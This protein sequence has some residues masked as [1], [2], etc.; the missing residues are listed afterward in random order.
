VEADPAYAP[1]WAR[2][3]RVNRVLGGYSGGD[4]DAYYREAEAAFRRALE[5]NPD[6]SLAHNLYT[7]L[8]VE[9]GQ[10]EAALLRLVARAHRHTGDPELFAGLVQACRYCGLL[11][12]SVA[13]YEHARRL[14]AHIR[15]SVAHA[16]FALGDYERAIATNVEDPPVLTAAALDGLGRTEEAV[17]L[18]RQMDEAPLPKVYRLFIGSMRAL[19]EGAH[20][21]ARDALR[22]M[23]QESSLRDPC[24]WYYIAR[25]MA[26]VGDT[27]RALTY[28]ERSVRGGFFC[29]PWLARDPWVDVLR[30]TPRFRAVLAEAESRHRAAAEAFAH[31][32]GDR[33]LGLVRA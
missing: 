20:G 26:Y 1:A 4:A 18:L 29:F 25:A 22:E 27:E 9:L 21:A 8:E 5:L 11:E 19:H 16:H 3:G 30:A 28:I 31:A 24:G 7:N 14:D 13:A 23:T 17:S 10:A 2:L 12:A 32:G 6:L 15:T 33:L